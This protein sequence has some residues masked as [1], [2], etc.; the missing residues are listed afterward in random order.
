MLDIMVEVEN[1]LEQITDA[2]VLR[3]ASHLNEIEEGEVPLGTIHD[4]AAYRL[5]SLAEKYQYRE[6]M[7]LAAAKFQADTVEARKAA[8]VEQ[9]RHHAVEEVVKN[10]FWITAKD[11]I[12]A[13]AWAAHGVGI[14]AGWMLVT[15]PPSQPD[16][17]VSAI[18]GL[19]P[20]RPE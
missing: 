7:A 6:V 18:A 3:S 20:F 16:R 17:L 19:L 15:T 14:R 1:E 11:A 13:E 5:W 2:D 4:P 8:E 9:A 12:G 10:L